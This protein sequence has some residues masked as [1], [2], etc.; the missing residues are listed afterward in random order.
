MN[1]RNGFSLGQDLDFLQD[2]GEFVDLCSL[3][4]LGGVFISVS[5]QHEGLALCNKIG[6]VHEKIAVEVLEPGVTTLFVARGYQS[7]MSMVFMDF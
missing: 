4:V 5:G 7:K 3:R 2:F 1:L 6:N